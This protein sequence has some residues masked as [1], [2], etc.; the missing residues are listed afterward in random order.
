MRR[1][2]DTGWGATYEWEDSREFLSATRIPDGV[3]RIR[4]GIDNDRHVALH[5]LIR[6]VHGTPL[7][8]HFYGA[9]TQRAGAD[10]PIFK[11]LRMSTALNTSFV[12]VH[13]PTLDI[14]GDLGIAW[15]EGHAG[16]PASPVIRAV[17]HHVSTVMAAPRVV[18]WGGSAGGFAALRNVGSIPNATALVWNPQTS[19][20]R[21]LQAPVKRYAQAA[22]DSAEL[23]SVRDLNGDFVFDLTE[24][25]QPNWTDAPIVYL[26]EADD[27]HVREHLS[28]LLARHHPDLAREV[29]LRDTMFGRI[30]PSF[31][32]HISHWKPGHTPP[33]KPAIAEF[34]HR[35]V[36]TR[37]PID[38]TLAT[39]ESTSRSLIFMTAPPDRTPPSFEVVAPVAPP[40]EHPRMLQWGS[41]FGRESVS[42][43]VARTPATV[44]RS[45][46]G[47]SIISAFR[48]RPRSEPKT[49]LKLSE[50]RIT[51][52][53][54]IALDDRRGSARGHLLNDSSIDI[55]VLDLL[56]EVRG[57]VHAGGSITLTDHGLLTRA[58]GQDTS[59]LAFGSPRHRTLW[60]KRLTRLHTDLA[61]TK[62][63]LIV[64]D[65]DAAEIATSDWSWLGMAPPSTE[66]IQTWQWAVNTARDKL[67]A[68]TWLT[69]KP[70]GHRLP[71]LAA[72]AGAALEKHLAH[73]PGFA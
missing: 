63:R 13:D 53:R 3:H 7:T 37:V 25:R 26:Q 60:V 71:E 38:E 54:R 17:L 67:S 21:Y 34:L 50:S 29:T 32:L 55:V 4:V 15:F 61:R 46:L 42:E 44:T 56:E 23:P 43:A 52:H 9:Q 19:I 20:A 27:R 58:D 72:L 30:T 14:D 59:H 24:Q 66:V 28:H 49:Y 12:L 6:E 18:L 1:L 16:F 48:A 33:P 45:I 51:E 5:V 47:Q 57:V 11:S 36:D 62:A 8:V 39:L 68:A 10:T 70:K 64:L 40:Q 35:L 22:F 65:V 73:R 2:L 69:I 31:Y 41:R